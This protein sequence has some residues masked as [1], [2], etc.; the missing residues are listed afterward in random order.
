[1]GAQEVLQTAF[2]KLQSLGIQ[3]VW[4]PMEFSTWN[5][6]RFL[7]DGGESPFFN[8]PWN[9]PEYPYWWQEMGFQVL[10]SYFS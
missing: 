5:S 7:V 9:P 3:K 2:T 8:E 4:G 1:M 6:Y 10:K